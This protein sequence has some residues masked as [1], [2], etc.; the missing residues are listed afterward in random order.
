RRP[1]RPGGRDGLSRDA[2][3]PQDLGNDGRADRHVHG[4]F[5]RAESREDR[6]RSVRVDRGTRR[7]RTLAHLAPRRRP[8]FAVPVTLDQHLGGTMSNPRARALADRIEQ[9]ANALATF[10]EGLSDA[11]WNTAVPGDGR[12]VGVTVHHVANM[13]P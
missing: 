10:A 3:G 6:V 13:Y 11:E 1:L 9:G 5:H 2:G 7:G 12:S 4:E 8:G